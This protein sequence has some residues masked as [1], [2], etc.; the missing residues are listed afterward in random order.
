MKSI[1]HHMFIIRWTLTEGQFLPEFDRLQCYVCKQTIT[2]P[3]GHVVLSELGK[4][5]SAEPDCPGCNKPEHKMYRVI[6]R[7]CPCFE[8]R[9]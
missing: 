6:R 8:G 9:I 4:L 2:G 1:T 3:A 7:D 5:S